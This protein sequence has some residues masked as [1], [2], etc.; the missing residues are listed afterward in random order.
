MNF[1]N[2]AFKNITYYKTKTALYFLTFFL[3]GNLLLIGIS[4]KQAGDNTKEVIKNKIDPIVSYEINWDDIYAGNEN[5]SN[6]ID[7][8]EGINKML[9]DEN[10]IASDYGF[11][12][13]G[14][15][16]SFSAYTLDVDEEYNPYKNLDVILQ[17]YE[18]ENI[19]DFSL[20]DFELVDGRLLEK[21]DFSSINNRVCLV[22]DLL[23]IQN[24]L[25]VGDYII[26]NLVEESVDT[27]YEI[28]DKDNII[29]EFEIVGIYKN[30]I[31]NFDGTSPYSAK[32]ELYPNTII[33]STQSI[34]DSIVE[35]SNVSIKD[36]VEKNPAEDYV[37]ENMQAKDLY[38]REAVFL[39]DSAENVDNF[40]MNYAMYT[41]DTLLLNDNG[42]SYI[43]V[44]KPLETI[45]FFSRV[46]LYLIIITSIIIIS[47]TIALEI[48][49]REFEIGIQLSHGISKFKIIGQ[50]IVEIMI[51][52]IVALTL[53]NVS[54]KI[55]SL[56]ISETIIRYANFQEVSIEESMSSGYDYFTNITTDEVEEQYNVKITSFTLAMVYLTGLLIVLISIITGSMI[57]LHQNPKK[58]LSRN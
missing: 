5:Q 2:R 53:S 56:N 28:Y 11:S 21:D 58:I 8:H 29:L 18:N 38:N 35:N 34:V 30:N 42:D 46:M 20:N 9:N 31:S 39:L 27:T 19:I 4:V 40:K 36:F 6:L 15:A 52:A 24:D 7:V 55:I 37:V 16:S 41:N 47:I 50:L 10:V 23:A 26:V 1:I 3:I 14:Y 33:I 22:N 51:V 57:I 25:K 54:G 43:N 17:G 44:M 48:K 45:D 49:S 32:F 13:H 12:R